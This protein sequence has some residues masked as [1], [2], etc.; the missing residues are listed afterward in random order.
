[1]N[2]AE[3]S[4]SWD[5]W[6]KQTYE[7]SAGAMRQW[8]EHADVDAATRAKLSFAAEQWIAAA[9]PANFL[10]TNPEALQRALDTKGES[11]TAGMKLMMSD[12]AKGRVSNT[13]ESAF[14]VGKNIAVSPG[15]VVMRNQLAELIQYSRP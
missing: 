6:V 8:V 5:A 3:K 2:Q 13:D 4:N 11:L 14:E 15:A 9:N 12:L 10:A 7:A 1:M